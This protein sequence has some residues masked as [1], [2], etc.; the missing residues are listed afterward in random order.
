MSVSFDCCCVRYGSKGASEHDG[1]EECNSFIARDY[2]SWHSREKK[3]RAGSLD[4]FDLHHRVNFPCSRAPRV[5]KAVFAEIL[6]IWTHVCAAVVVVVP[7]EITSHAD[8]L[9]LVPCGMVAHVL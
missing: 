8:F 3:K 1:S 6:D 2:D 5:M 9:R 7:H 4:H